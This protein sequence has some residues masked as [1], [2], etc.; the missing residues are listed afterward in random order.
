MGDF[1]KGSIESDYYYDFYDYKDPRDVIEVFR[2]NFNND[3]VDDIVMELLERYEFL[4]EVELDEPKD[5][6]EASLHLMNK[7]AFKP[8]DVIAFR[9]D[10][11]DRIV[12]LELEG[13]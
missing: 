11:V 1:E 6:I 12:E 2:E 10:L 7:G 13:K 4:P 5:Y 8:E 3:I 9:D